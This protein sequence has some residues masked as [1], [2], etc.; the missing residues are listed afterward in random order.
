MS[1][2]PRLKTPPVDDVPSLHGRAMDNL[3]FIR[4]TMEQAGSFTA[5]SGLA[6]V[7]VGA[8]ALVA[9]ALAWQLRR[10]F[11]AEAW[12]VVWVC[13]ALVSLAVAG[14]AMS[15]KA[16]RSEAQLLTGAGRKMAFSFAPPMFVGALLTVIFYRM[17]LTAL[18]PGVWLLLYGTGVVTGGAFSVQSVPVMGCCFMLAGA[19]TLL[20]CPPVFADAV[21]ATGFGGLHIAF[22]IYIARRHGG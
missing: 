10:G 19:V 9:A 21:M 8:S 15:R 3:R 17:G 12:V 2:A 7:A 16:R 11:G 14:V 22:G 13:E 5:V 18:L 6:M 4:E 1:S 20:F